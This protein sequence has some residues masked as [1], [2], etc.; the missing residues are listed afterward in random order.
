MHL[1][2]FTMQFF[3]AF[4]TECYFILFYFFIILEE[5]VIL[6]DLG[7]DLADLGL[8]DVIIE[9]VRKVNPWIDHP[10]FCNQFSDGLE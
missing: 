4:S 6:E 7:W 2:N 9:G 3:F 10:D 5:W 8:I 1:S